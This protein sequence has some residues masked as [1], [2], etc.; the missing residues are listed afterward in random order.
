MSIGLI[1]IW[2]S[3][4]TYK[5]TVLIFFIKLFA[6]FRW[7]CCC[8]CSFSIFFVVKTQNQHNSF[9]LCQFRCWLLCETSANILNALDFYLDNENSQMN[10]AS[11]D[12][13]MRFLYFKHRLHLR[14]IQIN[15]KR[16][17]LQFFLISSFVYLLLLFVIIAAKIRRTQTNSLF[18][19]NAHWTNPRNFQEKLK[20][21]AQF[22]CFF[23]SLLFCILFR[24]FCWFCFVIHYDM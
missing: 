21:G 22:F 1:S 5:S 15:A 19:A 16:S 7:I 24:R 14:C 13:M 12:Q 3:S 2:W 6:F 8:C 4:K 17:H 23:C 10:Q 18:V 11:F 20:K 9:I